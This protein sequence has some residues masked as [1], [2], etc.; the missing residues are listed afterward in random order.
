MAKYHINPTTGA[1][2]QC[3]ATKNC[4]FGDLETEHFITIKEAREAYEQSMG[5]SFTGGSAPS[6]RALEDELRAVK[7]KIKEFDDAQPG[8]TVADCYDKATVYLKE[9]SDSM[10]DPY[11]ED[12]YRRAHDMFKDAVTISRE[13]DLFLEEG[14]SSLIIGGLPMKR[15][16]QEGAPQVRRALR[17]AGSDTNAI[18]A[19]VDDL[20][21]KTNAKGERFMLDSRA[22]KIRAALKTYDI[23]TE[24][25]KLQ[26][27][28]EVREHLTAA[29]ATY[30]AEQQALAKER[31]QGGAEEAYRELAEVVVP[32]YFGR[33]PKW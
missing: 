6:R 29:Y 10:E 12:A 14:I 26:F 22:E 27:D 1:A 16:H 2:A 4:P 30:F 15:I 9:L 23:V 21:S 17:K 31:G 11:A 13:E 24:G 5:S 33:R 25:Q 28:R 7:Q 18:R 19:I 8:R 32:H 20:Q 3:K